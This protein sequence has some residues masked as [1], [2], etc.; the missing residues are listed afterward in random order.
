MAYLCFF[1]LWYINSFFRIRV[2]QNKCTCAPTVQAGQRRAV[3]KC[4]FF[5]PGERTFQKLIG[6]FNYPECPNGALEDEE[7]EVGF[8]ICLMKYRNSWLLGTICVTE[9][10]LP[11]SHA[12]SPSHTHSGGNETKC[13][14]S[15]PEVSGASYD[16]FTAADEVTQCV[17]VSKTITVGTFLLY[18]DI[19][20]GPHNFRDQT[21]FKEPGSSG[22]RFE[23]RV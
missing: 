21:Q 6:E 19:Q 20:S 1:L 4:S 17:S 2:A 10:L 15:I 13:E 14:G 18:E 8:N 22:A 5:S 9:S 11:T 12:V 3:G 16:S 7:E 23:L